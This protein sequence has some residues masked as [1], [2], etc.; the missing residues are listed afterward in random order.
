MLDAQA[1]NTQ[2]V[3]MVSR[4]SPL[5]SS[6]FFASLRLI[7]VFR[8]NYMVTCRPPDRSEPYGLNR[9]PNHGTEDD[10]IR[11]QPAHSYPRL[12]NFT[13]RDKLQS[14]QMRIQPVRAQQ[15]LMRSY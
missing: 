12:H 4:V 9:R 6:A 5:R 8:I 11:R 1:M 14:G 15:F 13:V 10:P 2:V 7:A 3:R